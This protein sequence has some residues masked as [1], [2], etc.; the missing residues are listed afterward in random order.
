MM[1]TRKILSLSLTAALAAA[2]AGLAQTPETPEQ[3]LRQV[4]A[5]LLAWDTAGARQLFDQLPAAGNVAAKVAAGRLLAQESRFDESAAQLSAAVTAAPGDPSPAIFLGETYRLAKR[6]DDLSLA[7]LRSAGIDPRAVTTWAARSAG[8]GRTSSTAPPARVKV[9]RIRRMR[10]CPM[11]TTGSPSPRSLAAFGRLR[12][13]GSGSVFT[14]SPVRGI[15]A[16]LH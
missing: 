14:G 11:E 5:R 2:G 9:S 7:T 4:D 6:A 16:S 8:P 15:P 12:R 1:S 13:R 3:I 10:W